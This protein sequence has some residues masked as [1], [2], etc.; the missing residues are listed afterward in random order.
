MG[1][2]VEAGQGFVEPTG[3]FPH[4]VGAIGTAACGTLQ[5]AD[6]REGIGRLGS[7]T[8][9]LDFHGN[10]L[11]RFPGI[12]GGHLA[13]YLLR[14]RGSRGLLHRF[15]GRGALGRRS[16]FPLGGLNGQFLFQLGHPKGNVIKIVVRIMIHHHA[17]LDSSG[18]A[19]CGGEERRFNIQING[20]HH[21]GGLRRRAAGGLHRSVLHRGG[22]RLISDGCRGLG[23]RLRN[24]SGLFHLLGIWGRRKLHGMGWLLLHQRPLVFQLLLASLA[25]VLDLLVGDVIDHLGGG[26]HIN[27]LLFLILP[28]VLGAV[29]DGAN[30]AGHSD[31]QST[32]QRQY[33]RNSDE[34]IGYRGSTSPAQQN[35]QSAA[36]DTAASPF[37][38][39]EIQIREQRQPTGNPLGLHGKMVDAAAEK[40]KGH[41]ADTAHGYC[42][43]SAEGIDDEQIQKSRNRKIEPSLS[44]EAGQKIVHG[45]QQQAVRLD[46]NDQKQ[47]KQNK[48]HNRNDSGRWDPAVILG[49]DLGIFGSCLGTFFSCFAVFRGSCLFLGGGTGCVFSCL[50][51]LLFCH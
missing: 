44:D 37:N 39:A 27:L 20:G 50:R 32:Q 11:G 49:S 26:L 46:A 8:P 31:V 14:R 15:G 18:V 2:D 1:I 48:T 17:C 7:G 40:H 16:R 22:H 35:S 5:K 29:D 19:V 21:P 30:D 38:S 34:N 13:G 10:L 41:G 43:F 23:Y 12:L 4:F 47:N 3:V 51:G 9:L 28:I 33:G 6:G 42:R 24:R 36:E 45:L 25:L